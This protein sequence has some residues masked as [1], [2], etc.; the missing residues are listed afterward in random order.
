MA[1]TKASQVIRLG[2]NWRNLAAGRVVRLVGDPPPDLRTYEAWGGTAADDVP[3]IDHVKDL[4]LA[5]HLR[6]LQS[7]PPQPPDHLLASEILRR[8]DWQSAD[9]DTA[10]GLGFPQALGT[11]QSRT[12]LGK[13]T[14]ERFYHG[15]AVRQWEAR[16]RDLGF[17]RGKT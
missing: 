12:L 2:Q 15:D 5:A 11:K 6:E 10:G 7:R 3:T 13:V 17:V 8:F 14:S 16:L 1:T 9:M 4:E